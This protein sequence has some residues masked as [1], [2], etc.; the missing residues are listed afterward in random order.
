MWLNSGKKLQMN[1]A[2][3][4]L[5]FFKPFNTL[6]DWQISDC[7]MTGLLLVRYN[8]D[9]YGII[10]RIPEILSILDLYFNSLL[11]FAFHNFTSPPR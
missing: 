5:S 1:N 2:K 6:A 7:T 8:V 9:F 11:K 3:F 10:R 4:E